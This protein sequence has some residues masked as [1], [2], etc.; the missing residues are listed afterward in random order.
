[1]QD[2]KGKDTMSEER[3]IL[4]EI[5]D[6]PRSENVK[7]EIPNMS[8]DTSEP[9][10]IKWQEEPAKNAVQLK[11]V[12]GKLLFSKSNESSADIKFPQKRG[13][14]F[15]IEKAPT[16]LANPP[17]SSEPLLSLEFAK[18]LSEARIDKNKIISFQP[19]GSEIKSKLRALVG[20]PT[21]KISPLLSERPKET[22]R[23][24][25]G[26]VRSLLTKPAVPLGCGEHK[27]VHNEACGHL[28]VMHEGHIDALHDGE[29]HLTNKS[30][31]V[32]PHKLAISKVNP[33]GCNP[34]C[35][36]KESC[37]VLEELM[38]PHVRRGSKGRTTRARTRRVR[39]CGRGSCA[40][41]R[42]TSTPRLA[43]TPKS[44]TATTSIT[45]LAA[46]ST[47]LTSNTATITGSCRS[48]ISSPRVIL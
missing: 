32:Y 9:R 13:Q 7:E 42:R 36:A 40:W 38:T 8:I 17:K 1:M 25:E 24:A 34:I 5:K 2:I 27:H 23:R 33:D 15:F 21:Q 41:K 45:W 10:L 29:L 35:S 44:S 46:N 26:V 43:D 31:R 48:T 20:F 12:K 18:K 30:G 47:S 11:T 6:K 37:E 22:S 39:F 28:L 3:V 14:T 4:K 16:K 19:F